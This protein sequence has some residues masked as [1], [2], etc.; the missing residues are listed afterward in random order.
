MGLRPVASAGFTLGTAFAFAFVFACGSETASSSSPSSDGGSASQCGQAL[1]EGSACANEAECCLVTVPDGFGPDGYRCTAGKWT[2]DRSCLPPPP[3]CESPLQGSLSRADS[4]TVPVTCFS[5][6]GQ[7]GVASAVLTLEGT[8]Y[9]L[10]VYFDRAPSAGDVLKVIA[11]S[12]GPRPD[13]GV[14]DDA[15]TTENRASLRIGRPGGFAGFDEA[16]KS[17]SGTLT[18]TSV[19]ASSP[20]SITSLRASID[21]QMT[22]TA[23]WAGALTGSW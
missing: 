19:Q 17:A 15:G 4:S 14:V 16:A 10:E 3:K 6:G 8:G 21:A 7:N 18:V 20:T 13:A 22:G 23:P 9:L 11:H 1:Q 5:P 2:G 12:Q